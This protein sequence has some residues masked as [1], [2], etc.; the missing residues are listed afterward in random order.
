M[1]TAFVGGG[2]MAEAMIARA[3]AEDVFT[4]RDVWAAEPME[5]RRSYLART[6]GVSTTASN[7][8]AVHGAA[9]VVLSVKP[10]HLP[11]VFHDLNGKL[12]A[13]Q[14]VL[15]IVAGV[16]IQKLVEGLMHEPVIRVMPN[17]PARI[18]AGMSVWTATAGVSQETKE[19]AAAL[20]RAMGQ[21]WYVPDETYLDMAT[22]LSGSGPAYV[23]AFIEALTEAGVYLGMPRDMAT[24]LAVETVAGSGL[25]AKETREHPAILREM[26]TSPGGTTAEGL[27]E[28]ERG[29][30]RSVVM[31]AVAAAF[32]KAKALGENA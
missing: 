10:Q 14:T 1:Q 28:L 32:K 19:T 20:L 22:A 5:S 26:V 17:T 11:H 31:E 23:F 21:E 7:S 9:L 13:D 2:I 4:A 12:T 16:S 15:S 27:R 29:K 30:L 6:Y 18:G 8:Q 3:I 25:L 24:M